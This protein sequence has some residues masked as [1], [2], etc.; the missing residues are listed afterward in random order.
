MK[1]NIFLLIFLFYSCSPHLTTYNQ[2]KTY[3]SKGFA[4]IYNENDFNDKI[5]KSRMNNEIMQIS[6]QSLR[7]GT[8]IKISNPVNKESIVLKNIKR[9]KYPDF[10]KILITKP[11]AKKLGLNIDLPLLEILEIKKNKSFV[12]EK[13]KI[14]NEEKKLPSKAPVASVQISNISN[15]KLNNTQKTN[16][17]IYILI[18]NFYSENTAKFLKERIIQDVSEIETKKLKIKKINEKETQIISGP[19]KSVNLLK[20]EY[21]KLKKFGFEELDIFI[22]E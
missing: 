2:K 16:K 7:T 18:G 6:H 1:F 14:Y 15:N 19:Y 22:N 11:V 13:A 8:L 12:A 17:Q 20:N 3:A 5:I 10:Y 4:Y 21:I 9:I